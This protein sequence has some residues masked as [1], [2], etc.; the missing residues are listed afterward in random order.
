[1]ATPSR[2]T[3][4][5]PPPRPR[6]GYPDPSRPARC[7]SAPFRPSGGRRP[8]KPQDRNTARNR[9]PEFPRP[10]P[11]AKAATSPTKLTAAAIFDQDMPANLIKGIHVRPSARP[12]RP[13]PRRTPYGA[14]AGLLRYLRAI[15]NPRLVRYS[16]VISRDPL[17]RTEV[18]I[19]MLIRIL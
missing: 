18:W 19:Y 8:S 16:S 15:R 5:S 17:V 10:I 13:A 1:M 4:P 2:S 14:I 6:A 9:F 12:E 11:T 3:K 7:K